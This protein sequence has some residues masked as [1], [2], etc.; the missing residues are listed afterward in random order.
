MMMI[1]AKSESD[2][3]IVMLD[4]DLKRGGALGTG[5]GGGVIIS[6]AQPLAVLASK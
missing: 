2:A 4:A 6:E 3:L 1:V 5:L